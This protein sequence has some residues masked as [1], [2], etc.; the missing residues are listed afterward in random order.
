MDLYFDARALQ[1]PGWQGQQFYVYHILSALI[2]QAEEHR[3]HLH[4]GWDDWDP[5]I[6][7]LCGP[8]QVDIRRHPGRVRS[9]LALPFEILRTRSRVHYRMYNEDAP[10]HV[11]MPCPVVINVLDNGRHLMPHYYGIS[12]VDALQRRTRRYIHEFAAIVTISQ[13]V[14]TEIRELFG[15][16]EEKIVVAPC[17]VES[18]EPTLLPVRPERL[19]AGRPFFLMMNPGNAHKNWQ[20]T[21]TAFARYIRRNRDDPDTLLALAGDLRTETAAIRAALAAD[22]QLAAR[23]VCTGY[24]S[25]AERLYCYRH[26]RLAVYPSR[27]DG[28]GI[29]V[30]EAQMHGLPVIV[31]NIPVLQEVSGGVA[32][33]VPLDQPDAITDAFEQVSRD[34]ALRQRLVARGCARRGV[35]SWQKSARTTLELLLALG[36][37]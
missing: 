1:R 26:A 35:Y 12:D 15:V 37:G 22:S 8:P 31:S 4:F 5:R 10:M 17:A 36:S 9:H 27:Y 33:T 18:P 2:A 34:E 21:L 3:L 23:V 16:P 11:P 29:P 7:L 32:Y 28:F 30:L 20:D 24:V 13:T 25:E 19:P 6:D 14:K